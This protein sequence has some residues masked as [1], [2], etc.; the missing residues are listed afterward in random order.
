MASCGMIYTP[1]S[2]KISTGNQAI[3]R[4]FF[5]NSRGCNICITMVITATI[6]EDVMLVLLIEGIYKVCQ[7]D[8]FMWHDIYTKF[9][10]D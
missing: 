5:R 7:R 4:F 6:C 8:G 3:L 9:H 10:E 1:S 2:M